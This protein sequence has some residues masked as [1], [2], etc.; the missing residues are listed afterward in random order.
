[1]NS[2]FYVSADEYFILTSDSI[3]KYLHPEAEYKII[4][5]NNI[6]LGNN[7]DGVILYDFR[8]GIIDSVTYKPAWGGKNG[9]SLERILPGRSSCDSSNWTS[10]L[11]ASLSTPGSVNS[12]TNSKNHNKSDLIINEIMPDPDIDNCEFIEFINLSADSI[13]I[14]GWR[15][16]DE[17]GNYNKLAESS[18]II[19]SGGYFLL[20]ADSIIYSKYNNMSGYINILG[21]SGL[22]FTNSGEMILLK[23]IKGNVVDSL[24]YSEDWHSRSAGITKN[25]S[26]ERI[27]PFIYS[28]ERSNWSS[29]TDTEGA[30]PGEV[31]SIYC[32]NPNSGSDINV[33]PNPFSPD[34]D[35]FE[36]H[37]IINY[38]LKSAAASLR[39]RI[40]DSVGREVRTVVNNYSSASNGSVIFDGCN[41]SG[42]PLRIG[43]YIILLE[44]ISD[45]STS[46][47]ILKTVVV[48]ARKL[49]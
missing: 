40:F 13:N 7:G 34:G 49:D 17:K 29:S 23:D 48:V 19:P 4:T 22:D 32:V 3:F 26:I 10:S 33:A 41:D 35:G 44:A 24:Y 30:T 38:K 36:D 20:A 42:Q 47:E 28:N 39:V 18:F 11:S 15:I 27:S 1:V 31:N 12:M 16:E 9:Y 37:C 14:G 46:A 25:L 2:D 21:N 45:Y 43:I 5:V 6:S 8:E